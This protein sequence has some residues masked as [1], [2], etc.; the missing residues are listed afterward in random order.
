MYPR[1]I[2]PLYADNCH[3]YL[4]PVRACAFTHQI[5]LHIVFCTIDLVDLTAVSTSLGMPRFTETNATCLWQLSFQRH[6]WSCHSMNPM[7]TGIQGSRC[8][9]PGPEI[10]LS[11]Q[12][13]EWRNTHLFVL[14]RTRGTGCN[15]ISHKHR[16]LLIRSIHFVSLRPRLLYVKGS[17]SA[18][19]LT[20]W[21]QSPRMKVK[22]MWRLQGTSY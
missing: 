2:T 16:L 18:S 9:G 13:S 12:F 1:H 11:R 5:A 21:L 14:L 20:V 3:C 7:K 4:L 19:S 6:K 8:S 15:F 10:S 22:R 17:F